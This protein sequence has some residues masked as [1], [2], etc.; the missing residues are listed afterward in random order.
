[1]RSPVSKMARGPPPPSGAPTPGWKVPSTLRPPGPSPEGSL[2]SSGDPD[3]GLG[4]EGTAQPPWALGV[5]PPGTRLFCAGA[6]TAAGGAQGQLPQVS[7]A[8]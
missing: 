1:M 7:A 5:S 8:N 3:V 6:G 2:G 4:L